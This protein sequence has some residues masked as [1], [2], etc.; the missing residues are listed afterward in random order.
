M[1]STRT[2]ASAEAW[3]QRFEAA[4]IAQLARYVPEGAR[5]T[6]ALSGGVD[7][8]VLLALLRRAAAQRGH[9]LQA[10]HVNHGL[11]PQARQWERFC[12]LHCARR[13]VPF[14]ALRVVVGG[15]GANVEAEAR[16]ARYRAFGACA[17]PF[18]A[19]A[20][21]RDDQAET[22]LLNLVRGSGVYG[23]AGMPIRRL[24]V[25]KAGKTVTLVRPLLGTGRDEIERYARMRRLTWIEDESNRDR[26]FARNFVRLEV[27]PLLERRFTGSRE[28]LARSA[29]H[30]AD[31]ACLLDQLA[32][33]DCAEVGEEDRLHAERLGRMGEVRAAN[34]L[35]HYL[36]SRGEPPPG[37]ARTREMLRQLTQ[38]RPDAT[39][40]IALRTGSLRRFR[41]WIALVAH[42]SGE[43]PAA[44][45]YWQGEPRLPLAA[46]GELLAK[47][48]RGDGVSVR[49]LAQAPVTVRWREG[50]ERI[51]LASGARTRTV[52]NLLREAG[53]VPWARQRM[54]LVF[55]GGELVWVPFV[56]VAAD[57][58][59]AAGER[60]WRFSWK[61]SPSS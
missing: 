37:L 36:A 21:H 45:L 24:L 52:K 41:G 44:R 20:H 51:R 40:A 29:A 4:F 8:I 2:A 1:A 50:G 28:A 42:D 43:A 33:A 54:P 32:A 6:A 58:Q 53:V 11:S 49:R 39:P 3:Q 25:R 18:L 30:L 10:L 13:K 60:A 46:Y 57:Y 38:A 61:P 34:V 31:A 19:L 26:R 56:G 5:I 23:L 16:A 27:L 47:P 22:L 14:R 17:T 12:R 55:C 35:R 15:N 59:A 48:T 7:S 9:A